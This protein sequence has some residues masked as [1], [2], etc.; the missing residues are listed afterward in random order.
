MSV[1]LPPDPSF[2]EVIIRKHD[3][4]SLQVKELSWE[5]IQKAENKIGLNIGEPEKPQMKYS[6]N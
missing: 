5:R 6:V 3:Q 2:Y 4:Y 1:G